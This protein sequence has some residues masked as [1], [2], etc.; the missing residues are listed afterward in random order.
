MTVE[1]REEK[2]GKP[3]LTGSALDGD[4]FRDK[5]DMETIPPETQF[6]LLGTV[7]DFSLLTLHSGVAEVKHRVVL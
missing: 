3:L 6:S 5:C 7:T 4:K 1:R 2:V